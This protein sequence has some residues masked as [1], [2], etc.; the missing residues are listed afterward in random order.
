MVKRWLSIV[1][2]LWLCLS[3]LPP[4]ALAAPKQGGVLKVGFQMIKNLDPHFANY[5]PEMTLN[6]NVY[7]HLTVVDA[8]NKVLPDLATEWN[9]T[10]SKVWTFKIQKDAKFSTGTPVTAKDVVFSYDRVR[11][12][13]VGTPLV[14][15]FAN[16][17][18]IE[19]TDDH[20]VVFTLKNPNPEF[21]AD[22]S[23]YQCCVVPAGSDPSKQQI[24][25]GYYMIS[26]YFPEDRIILKRNPHFNG[27]DGKGVQLPYFDEMQIIFSP[28]AAGQM[29]ALRG[30]EIDFQ[31][32]LTVELADSV[33]KTPSLKLE[34]RESNM[35]YAIHLRA[36]QG[37]IGSNPKIA[38]AFKLAT[39]HEE[40]VNAVRPGLA[41]M[42]NDTPVGPAFGDYYLNK[43]PKKDIEKAKQILAEAGFPKG[44]DIKVTVPNNQSIVPIATVWKEQLAK[45]GV[46]AQIQVI[47]VDMY[48]GSSDDSWTKCEVGITNWGPRATPVTYFKL[49]YATGAAWNTAHWSDTEFD[50]LTRQIDS[51][52]DRAKRI[53][54]Y[55]KAQEILIERSPYIISLFEKSAAGMKKNLEGVFMPTSWSRVRFGTAYFGD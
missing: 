27:K 34:T 6:E 38:Q 32:G 23:E 44:M 39:D 4:G 33:R 40:I 21:A 31:G 41:F 24:G 15:H 19:A 35:H 47:P 52:L 37:H 48:F 5:A 26:Q 16:V 51:E 53:E 14:K 18:K 30:G 28:D 20:T 22:V 45:I 36:D 8:T 9:T 10:D 25:S 13:K 54:L 3:V 42:G 11:D 43:P 55:K 1:S 17:E 7:Q 12:P 2:V 50:E 29:E 46:R 49:A